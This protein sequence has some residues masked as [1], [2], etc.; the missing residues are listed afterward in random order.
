MLKPKR[1]IHV[2]TKKSR[3]PGLKPVV[4]SDKLSRIGHRSYKKIPLAGIETGI[5]RR[6]PM[7][8]HRSYKKIPLAGI[9][10]SNVPSGAL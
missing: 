1:C 9:E 3:L 5:A 8:R 4:G 2:A 6:P 10:T 7:E